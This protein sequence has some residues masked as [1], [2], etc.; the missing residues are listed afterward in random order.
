MSNGQAL[1]YARWMRQRWVYAVAMVAGVALASCFGPSEHQCGDG[2]CGDGVCEATGYCSFVTVDDPSCA[3]RYGVGAGALAGTCALAVDGGVD[4]PS[5][6]GGDAPTDAPTDACDDCDGDGV[7][8]VMDNCPAVAN[9]T[10][11][12]E[13][14]DALGDACDNC[15]HLSNRTQVNGDGDDLGDACDPHRNSMNP[16]RILL[17]DGFGT[18]S[19]L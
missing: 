10:Q 17:F 7:P 4:A 15:P 3:R 16:D 8:N 11:F 6:A 12:D 19:P 13:D 2:D 1:R 9:P 18:S 14:N 5:D